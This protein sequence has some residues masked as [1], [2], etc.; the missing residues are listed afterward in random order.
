MSKLFS[1][2]LLQITLEKQFTNYFY[3]FKICQAVMVPITLTGASIL[4]NAPNDTLL[5]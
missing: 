2:Y 1:H 4:K 3:Y 5:L